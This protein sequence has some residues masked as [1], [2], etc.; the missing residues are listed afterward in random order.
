[1]GKNIY[2]TPRDRNKWNNIIQPKYKNNS[3]VL[4]RYEKI[5]KLK[6]KFQQK[7]SR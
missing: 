5:K 2:E 4:Q 7:K 6:E 1:M 3:D